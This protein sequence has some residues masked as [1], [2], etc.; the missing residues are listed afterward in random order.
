MAHLNVTRNSGKRLVGCEHLLAAATRP[1]RRRIFGLGFRFDAEAEGKSAGRLPDSGRPLR[2]DGV[3]YRFVCQRGRVRRLGELLRFTEIDDDPRSD[4]RPPTCRLDGPCLAYQP[5]HAVDCADADDHDGCRKPKPPTSATTPTPAATPA[6]G[7]ATARG[8][9]P[10]D[11]DPPAGTGRRLLQELHRRAGRTRRPAPRGRA[12]LP[13]RPRRRQRRRGL[14]VAV[15]PR[16]PS[17]AKTRCRHATEPMTRARAA[18]RIPD[19]LVPGSC[20]QRRAR[21]GVT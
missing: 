15:R 21:R 18:Q 9:R 13:Q 5:G 3:G 14:R 17:D 11:D 20:S 1:W 4:H 10:S 2:R 6:A 19:L 12:R 16:V 7:R 8:R